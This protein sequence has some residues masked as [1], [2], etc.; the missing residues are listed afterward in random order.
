MSVWGSNHVNYT[1]NDGTNDPLDIEGNYWTDGPSDSNSKG[2]VIQGNHDITAP[3]QIP[4]SITGAAGLE[5]GFAAV[6]N[7][8]P[9]I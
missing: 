2:V 9:A 7:W 6:L 1:L 5:P 3:G 8:S 4:S